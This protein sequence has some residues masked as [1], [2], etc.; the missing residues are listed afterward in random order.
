MF[1]VAKDIVSPLAALEPRIA[2]QIE[3]TEIE[4]RKKSRKIPKK[5]KSKRSADEQLEHSGD[6]QD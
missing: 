2:D 3:A 5:Q 6:E 1:V 4:G